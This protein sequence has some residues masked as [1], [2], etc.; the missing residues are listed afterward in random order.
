MEVGSTEAIKQAVTADLGVSIVSR[1]AVVLETQVKRLCFTSV[2]D[3]KLTRQ[4]FVIY[5]RRRPLSHA[6]ATFLELLRTPA[7]GLLK[8]HRQRRTHS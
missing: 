5:H 4:L 1:Y 6:G 7:T 3:L 2:A 8:T